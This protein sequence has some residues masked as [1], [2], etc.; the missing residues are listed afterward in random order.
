MK[1]CTA[2]QQP[3]ARGIQAARLPQGWAV[4]CLASWVVTY[5]ALLPRGCLPP[6]QC[7]PPFIPIV[8]AIFNSIW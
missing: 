8:M 6:V 7:A 3:T 2:L 4:V 1:H 5:T